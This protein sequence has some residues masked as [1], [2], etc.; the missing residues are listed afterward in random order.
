MDIVG[1]ESNEMSS[2]FYAA[3][4]II[5]DLYE[6]FNY[7]ESNDANLNTYTHRNY[8]LLPRTAT[9]FEV[10]CK[11]ILGDSIVLIGRVIPD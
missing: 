7:I 10:N 8:E 9:E 5:S 3:R 2:L 11:C 6:L 4:L 1:S